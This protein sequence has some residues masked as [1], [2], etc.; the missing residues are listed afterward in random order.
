ST[1]DPDRK[2]A[3]DRPVL[4]ALADPL[5]LDH[6]RTGRQ[7]RAGRDDS[8][9]GA[10]PVGAALLPQRLQLPDPAHVALA[11]AG[12]AVAYPVLLGDDLAVELVLIALLLRQ[13][14]VAPVLEM[15][16]PTLEA[17]RP[18][19]VEPDCAARQRR[20]KAPVV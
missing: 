15:G 14:A 8:V 17:A 11:P 4:V 7:R 12:D 9:A 10:G 3:D 13:H 2:V 16:E 20:Q 19:A 18:S 6:Q 1:P 5:G